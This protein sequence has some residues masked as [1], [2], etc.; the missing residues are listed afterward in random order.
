[1]GRAGL[2]AR[3]PSFAPPP[4]CLAAHRTAPPLFSFDPARGETGFGDTESFCATPTLIA[5]DGNGEVSPKDDIGANR[6]E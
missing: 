2:P 3:K 4:V 6:R 5:L 1:M